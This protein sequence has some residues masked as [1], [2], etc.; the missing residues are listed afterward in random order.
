MTLESSGHACRSIPIDALDRDSNCFIA[1]RRTITD[2][3]MAH[4][5]P[6]VLEAAMSACRRSVPSVSALPAYAGGAFA[7][8]LRNAAIELGDGVAN[9]LMARDLPGQALRWTEA[10]LARWPTLPSTPAEHA[11]P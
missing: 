7:D 11:P 4:A 9:S 3:R 6:A 10:Y 2:A 8:R 5:K 1:W